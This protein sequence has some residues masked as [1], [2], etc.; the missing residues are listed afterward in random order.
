MLCRASD[1]DIPGDETV[2]WS[3]EPAWGDEGGDDCF[4]FQVANPAGFG[5]GGGG[6]CPAEGAAEDFSKAAILSRSEPGFF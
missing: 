4:G 2:A 1:A 6:G 5:R 3:V